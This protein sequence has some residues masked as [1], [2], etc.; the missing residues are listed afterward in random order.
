[1]RFPQEYPYS[2][3][4]LKFLTPLLH[5]NVYSVRILV[6]IIIIIIIVVIIIS[7]YYY[8]YYCH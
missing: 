1:M 5:P 2:P 8:Y 6:Y 3:P 7:I 4:R